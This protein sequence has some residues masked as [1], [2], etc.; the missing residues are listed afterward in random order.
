MNII[1][2]IKFHVFVDLALTI[3]TEHINQV[4]LENDSIPF[5]YLYCDE[6]SL[7]ADNVL[8]TLY[9]AKKYIMPHLEHACVEYLKTN[10]SADN[11]CKLL[12]YCRLFE[13]TEAIQRF[14]DVIDNQTVQV[15][16]SDSF[17]DI[18]YETLEEILSRDTLNA[19]E[20]VI[21]NAANRWAEAE[22]T[23]Q[24]RDANSQNCREVLGGALYLLRF[25]T[26]TLDEFANG[27]GQSGLLNTQETNDIFFY[28]TA[29]NKPKLRFPTARRKVPE[30]NIAQTPSCGNG[31][32]NRGHPG[33]ARH[34]A[35]NSFGRA[36]IRG[37]RVSD[38]DLDLD[39]AW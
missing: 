23:R 38:L 8:S 2:M 37:T 27:P 31:F 39:G 7:K 11:A 32:G 26:M 35:C 33:F 30:K 16:Q 6:I 36:N 3:S 17:T 5:R 4:F 13:E 25:S 15:L 24:G 9:A 19:E 10:V 12:S 21:F 18:D 34:P 29:R 28:H 20:I 1:N 14:W 22:C